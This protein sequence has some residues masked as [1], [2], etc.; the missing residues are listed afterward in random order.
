MS[1]LATRIL[2]ITVVTIAGAIWLHISGPMHVIR[3]TTPIDQFAPFWYMLSA[4]PFLGML[5]AD[6]LDLYR[7]TGFSKRHWN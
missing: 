3:I 4:F 1:K 6:L 5:L 2:I 7:D